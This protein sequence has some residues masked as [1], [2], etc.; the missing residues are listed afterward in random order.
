M[1]EEIKKLIE[2]AIKDLQ[3]EKK[4]PEFQ[5]PNISIF[6]SKILSYGDYNTD[7]LFKLNKIYNISPEVIVKPLFKKITSSN[8][9]DKFDDVELLNGFINFFIKD[10]YLQNQ[11][12][13][14]LKEKDKFGNLNLEEKVHPV[15][16]AKGGT[17]LKAKQFNRV[18]IEFI[19]ANPTGPLTLG[20]GR[21][22]FCGDA[23]ANIL[24]KAGYKVSREYYVNDTGNQINKLGHSVIGD[25]EAVYKGEYINELQKKIKGNNPQDIGEKASKV[26]FEKM[27]KPSVKKM[28][29]KFDTWFSE[30]TLYKN[31]E[32]DEAINE[33]SKK[34]FTYESEGALW[35]RSKDLGDD[36]DRVLIRAD[37]IKTYFASDI[38]Y[39]KNKFKRDFN[40]L[41]IFLGAD[42]YG[43]V[44]R[45][46]AASHAL[47]FG[48]D[49]IDAIVMQL[50]RLFEKGKEVRMSKRSGIYVTIDE[51]IDE[52]GLDVARFFFLMIGPN[53]HLNFNLDLAKEKSEK[54]PVFKV[55]YAYAR[56]CSIIRKSKNFQF[57]IFNFQSNYNLKLLNEK[58]E[59]ELIKQL[60][61]FPEIVEDIAKDYQVQRLPKYAMELADSFHKF[62]ENCQVISKNKEL[63]KARLSLISATKIV[64]KNTL[65]LMGIST[66]ERM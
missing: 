11:L 10:E 57:S 13:V 42:H 52:V 24:E 19:S 38:A 48:E 9:Y 46:K 2:K 1:K 39:L 20:N 21:G 27:I 44:A 45:L 64:S 29:V 22:G 16:S 28:G 3:K 53:T 26:I 63:T 7:I 23:L 25:A 51:L 4:L 65:D 60:I 12:E 35:F 56:I 36:K 33:L 59:L 15:K 5:I 55:Q 6:N 66:P 8:T 49:S 47:G 34:G 32:V 41:I 37:G 31:K 30:K 14:I 58:S 18:N 50:V 62:Y 40:K 17:S 54:N 43:Y 61:R